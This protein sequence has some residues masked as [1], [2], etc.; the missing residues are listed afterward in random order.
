MKLNR[1]SLRT[2]SLAF[3][4]FCSA[5]SASAHPG[6]ALTDAGI[7]HLVT[8]PDHLLFLALAGAV[9]SLAGRFVHGRL[10]RWTLHGM[11]A[12]ALLGAIVLL[13]IRS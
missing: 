8:S 9:L 10:P 2:L 11:G 5:L 3:A 4:L 12:L 6:H 13:G 7:S 1:S